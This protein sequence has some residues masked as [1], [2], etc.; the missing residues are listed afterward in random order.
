MRIDTVTIFPAM[1]DSFVGFGILARAIKNKL[2]QVNTHN[3]RDYTDNVHRNVDDRPYGGGPGMVLMAAPAAKAIQHAKQQQTGK[4]STIYLSP[5]GAPLNQAKV[6]ALAQLD[7]MI[8]LA[9]RYQGI[10]ERLLET[11]IDE[12]ISLGDYV[13]NGGEVAVMVLIEA[14]AR[15]LAGVLGDEN[16]AQLDSFAF[17]L[18]DYPHYTRPAEY[19][20]RQVPEVLMQGDHAQ[21]RRW[22]LKQSLG[23]T[24][25]KRSDLLFGRPLSEEEISLLTE[26]AKEHNITLPQQLM[27]K[28]ND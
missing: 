28:K 1:I 5:Q 18:L 8:L 16:S 6:N 25:K 19:Q 4:F 11:E 3:P 20:G 15:Q 13:L 14:I 24:L 27:S 12:E 9:G 26:Y 23:N 21:V 7:G 22:C 17:G 10:D 2:L